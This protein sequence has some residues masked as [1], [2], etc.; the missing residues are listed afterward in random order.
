M[1]SFNVFV[2]RYAKFVRI[3]N[4]LFSVQNWVE[5]E[6]AAFFKREKKEF[7]ASQNQAEIDAKERKVSLP[8]FDSTK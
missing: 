3:G 8:Q 2:L 4:C 1:S 6:K 5:R 7:V